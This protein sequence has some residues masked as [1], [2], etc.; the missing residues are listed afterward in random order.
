MSTRRFN[1]AILTL[2]LKSFYDAEDPISDS[3]VNIQIR[4]PQRR[5]NAECHSLAPSRN[6]VAA[7]LTQHTPHLFII[8]SPKN[9]KESSERA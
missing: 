4:K 3:N 2:T 5:R 1:P 8:Q 7:T 6:S 9:Q